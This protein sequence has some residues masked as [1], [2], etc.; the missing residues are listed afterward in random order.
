MA[1]KY[2]VLAVIITTIARHTVYWPPERLGESPE[3][4]PRAVLR[5]NLPEPVVEDRLAPQVVPQVVH[6]NREESKTHPGTSEPA[7]SLPHWLGLSAVLRLGQGCGSSFL[8]R[9][10]Y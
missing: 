4:A 5:T 9:P 1:I 2:R 6:H 8:P 10:L 3:E 7:N